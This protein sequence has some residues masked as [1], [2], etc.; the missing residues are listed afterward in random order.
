MGNAI[1]IK[2]LRKGLY[3]D[4]TDDY[5]VIPS[6]LELCGTDSNYE[7][8]FTVN[9]G[10]IISNNRS[11]SLDSWAGIFI[12]STAPV[13]LGLNNI[14]LLQ[15]IDYGDNGTDYYV[16][17]VYCT[18][19]Q[20]KN[21][22]KF[23]FIIDRVNGYYRIYIDDVLQPTIITFAE[24]IPSFTENTQPFTFTNHRSSLSK[25]VYLNHNTNLEW[26]NEYCV[27]SYY[28]SFTVKTGSNVYVFDMSN[29][30]GSAISD[31]NGSGETMQIYGATWGDKST[32]RVR[33]IR[34]FGQNIKDRAMFYKTADGQKR[35]NL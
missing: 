19:P 29:P 21:A 18:I 20:L 28:N 23:R 11:A 14:A 6:F 27:G 16:F 31:S 12:N 35:V 26:G 2:D 10:C 9:D 32:P 17:N 15:L 5:A 30:V 25:D 24:N 8:E 1:F 34:H 3:F 22:T 33:N 7:L 4:G 13:S